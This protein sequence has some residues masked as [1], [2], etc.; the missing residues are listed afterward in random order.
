VQPSHAR[1]QPQQL[2]AHHIPARRQQVAEG[3]DEV[4]QHQQRDDPR[5]GHEVDQHGAGDQRGAEAGDA[6]DDVGD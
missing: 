3:G 4:Q 5:Q 6:E 2:A 1:Q